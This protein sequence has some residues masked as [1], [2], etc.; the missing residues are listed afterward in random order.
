MFLARS[1]VVV[2]FDS[3]RTQSRNRGIQSDRVVRRFVYIIMACVCVY[4]HMLWGTAHAPQNGSHT[5]PRYDLNTAANT[6]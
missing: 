3:E 1:T 6:L 2:E 4:I 5:D